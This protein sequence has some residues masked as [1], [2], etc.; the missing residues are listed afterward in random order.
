MLELS[1]DDLQEVS[2]GFLIAVVA[3]APGMPGG[4]G[5]YNSAAGDGAGGVQSPGQVSSI[6]AA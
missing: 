3:A 2:G 4:A 6:I 5:S 1:L